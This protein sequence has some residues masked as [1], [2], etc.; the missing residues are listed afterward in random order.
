M[1]PKRRC[2][3][4]ITVRTVE[5]YAAYGN[6]TMRPLFAECVFMLRMSP[7][8]LHSLLANSKEFGIVRH[9]TIQDVYEVIAGNFAPPVQWWE[10]LREHVATVTQICAEQ[11]ACSRK[12]RPADLREI[13][14]VPEQLSTFAAL[15]LV[16][17]LPQKATLRGR[18]S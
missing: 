14:R 2:R 9:P 18:L 5:D 10:A 11:Y 13:D 4:E 16:L 8:E 6:G 12:G 15:M 1:K 3:E 7:E 17:T